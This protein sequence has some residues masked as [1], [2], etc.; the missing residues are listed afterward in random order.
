M[1]QLQA[2]VFL[3]LSH[4]DRLSSR[5]RVAILRC[6]HFVSCRICDPPPEVPDSFRLGLAALTFGSTAVCLAACRRLAPWV[7]LYCVFSLARVISRRTLL[8][9]VSISLLSGQWL[10]LPLCPEPLSLYVPVG[11]VAFCEL[12]WLKTLQK[13][14]DNMFDAF[15]SIMFMFLGILMVFG[16]YP[17]LLH[18]GPAL[19]ESNAMRNA[20]HS[21]V[22]NGARESESTGHLKAHHGLALDADHFGLAALTQLVP[23]AVLVVG[24]PVLSVVILI[25]CWMF[26]HM[27]KMILGVI[28]TFF[29]WLGLYFLMRI[30]H[31]PFSRDLLGKALLVSVCIIMYYAFARLTSIDWSVGRRRVAMIT[32]GFGFVLLLDVLVGEGEGHVSP[33]VLCAALSVCK[34]AYATVENALDEGHDDFKLHHIMP[35]RPRHDERMV[36]TTSESGHPSVPED[37]TYEMMEHADVQLHDSP[38]QV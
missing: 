34:L 17:A 38:S 37:G 24:V 2:G 10:L 13:T 23:L 18:Y 15:V 5:A 9:I 29:G 30:L 32:A 27:T 7:S 26:Q 31:I 22:A 28:A 19:V 36:A 8:V 20:V 33:E 16:F 12:C 6:L 14:L 11:F 21:V 35:F 4:D 3:D 25:Y 1:D